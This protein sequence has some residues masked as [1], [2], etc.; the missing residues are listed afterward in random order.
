MP[1]F[2]ILGQARSGTTYLQT[3]LNSHPDVHC[4]GELFDPWQI[5]DNGK[6]TKDLS[7]IEARDRDPIAFFER[8]MRGEGLLLPSGWMGAKILFQHNPLIFSDLIANDPELVILSV[9]RS[10]KLA[11]FASL[12]QVKKSGRWT[13]TGAA[14]RREVPKL[15]A[16]PFWAK[17]ECNRLENEGFF[18]GHWLSGLPNPVLELDYASLPLPPTQ[19][20][21]ADFLSITQARF[22][23]PL[24]K[25]GQNRIL[26]RFENA[27]EIEAHFTAIGKGAW[28]G[29]ELVG[30]GSKL[31]C[32]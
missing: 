26:D 32:A 16:H 8:M 20:K 2:V 9:R 27:D 7:V 3:L 1:R 14:G 21:V 19:A 30:Y 15:T 13:D 25:Q 28:L 12:Q 5:D 24:R 22:S 31:P 29:P 11:Q 6:K 17:A 4:R 23:S 10:N 18:L